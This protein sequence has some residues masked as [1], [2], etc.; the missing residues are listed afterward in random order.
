MNPGVKKESRKI[1]M[2]LSAYTNSEHNLPVSNCPLAADSLTL[3]TDAFA[4]AEHKNKLIEHVN[5]IQN[6]TT[7]C[8]DIDITT[9][10]QSTVTESIRCTRTRRYAVLQSQRLLGNGEL[11]AENIT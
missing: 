4:V 8:G 1:S 3:L 5:M 9:A 11:S 7:A 2:K 6:H 10:Y